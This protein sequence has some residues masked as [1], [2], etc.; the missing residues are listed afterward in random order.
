MNAKR[1]ALLARLLIEACGGLDEAA[2]VDDC[3]LKKTRLALFCDPNAEAFMPADVLAALEAYC[4]KPI[5]SAALVEERPAKSAIADLADEACSMVEG[6]AELQELLR[7][8]RGGTPLNARDRQ[9]VER[10]LELVDDHVRGART[11][12]HAVGT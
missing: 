1:H 4:G 11:K 8:H 6:A 12:V 7:K 9:H 3:R 5:Y 2:A 10:L